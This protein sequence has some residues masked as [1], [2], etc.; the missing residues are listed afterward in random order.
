MKL[1]DKALSRYLVIATISWEEGA[2]KTLIL[3]SKPL[4]SGYE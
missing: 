4:A 2:G 3:S 1:I